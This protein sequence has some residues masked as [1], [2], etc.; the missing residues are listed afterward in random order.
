[1]TAPVREEKE[2]KSHAYSKKI[3]QYI[4]YAA[5]SSRDEILMDFVHYSIERAAGYYQQTEKS[6]LA[7]S[8]QR[9]QSP[10]EEN[11]QEGIL[12]GVEDVRAE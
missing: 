9:I 7:L 2:C 3:E 10:R 12:E 5:G 11:R 1:V 4:L 8:Q 6:N